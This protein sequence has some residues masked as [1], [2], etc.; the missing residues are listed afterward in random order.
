MAIKLWLFTELKKNK[1]KAKT[2][3]IKKQI[4]KIKKIKILKSLVFYAPA[5]QEVTC[6]SPGLDEVVSSLWGDSFQ[7]RHLV[8]PVRALWPPNYGFWTCPWWHPDLGLFFFRWSGEHSH[9]HLTLW[10][11]A[12]FPMPQCS[13]GWHGLVDSGLTEV[14]SSLRW[15]NLPIWESRHCSGWA[16]PRLGR[17]INCSSLVPLTW[18][19][20]LQL[21]Y[22]F[23][24]F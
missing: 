22:C 23:L 11:V 2:K 24:E 13:Q 3:P 18:R 4:L 19:A 10:P 9:S 14:A 12:A 15:A 7:W 20:F 8:L 1:E 21:L 5:S 16:L 17:N 6:K